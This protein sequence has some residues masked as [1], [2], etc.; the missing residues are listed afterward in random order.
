MGAGALYDSKFFSQGFHL[1][2]YMAIPRFGVLVLR[3]ICFL[4]IALGWYIVAL[5]LY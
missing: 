3:R 5:I 2:L 1:A 4:V